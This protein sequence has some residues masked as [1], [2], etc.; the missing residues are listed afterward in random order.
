M[1][2]T[3]PEDRRSGGAAAAPA[4]D[5]ALA[6]ATIIFN[7]IPKT[8]GT[9]LLKF[10]QTIFG[11]DRCF[12]H[13]ARDGR[14]GRISPGIES[15]SAGDLAGYR[16]IAGHFN[17]GNHR[18]IAGPVKYLCVLRDP[19]ERLVSDYHYNRSAGR[20]DLK[21]IANAMSF[22]DYVRAKIENPKSN[23]A[24]SAQIEFVAGPGATPAGARRTVREEY[25][26]CCMTDQLDD[27]Q[28]MLAQLYGRADLAPQW[29]NRAAARPRVPDLPPAL[30]D[31]LYGRFE[32]DLAFLAWVRAQFAAR[33]RDVTGQSGEA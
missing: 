33:C 21:A 5:P 20:A 26:A 25:L 7:H 31:D 29:V 23:M 10:F 17:Y 15:L 18:R 13:R 14:T 3:I 9:S 2:A 4:A 6:A 22:E 11:P 30:L 24:R 27:L 8:G 28:R 32:T 16:F 1:A 19:V 12:R